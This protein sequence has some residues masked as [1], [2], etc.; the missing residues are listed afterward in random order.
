MPDDTR[1]VRIHMAQIFFNSGG[2]IELVV[3]HPDFG[4][5]VPGEEIE[6]LNPTITADDDNRPDTW[7]TWDWGLNNDSNV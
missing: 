7:M 1:I 6:L 4:E 2:T 5:H 3:E